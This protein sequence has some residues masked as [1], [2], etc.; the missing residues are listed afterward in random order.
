MGS[1]GRL[2]A[3]PSGCDPL[4][5]GSPQTEG[6]TWVTTGIGIGMALGAF[7]AGGLVDAF[8]ARSGFC[9][10]AAAA[11]VAL[12]IVTLGRRVLGEPRP[13]ALEPDFAPA[14]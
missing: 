5:G 14:E 2:Q 11:S 7:V 8:G 6:V 3:D 12:L 13:Q 1:G 4:F 9:V 10:S